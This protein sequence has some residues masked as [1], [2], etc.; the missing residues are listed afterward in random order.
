MGHVLQATNSAWLLRAVGFK[1]DEAGCEEAL[2][3][4]ATIDGVMARMASI[5]NGIVVGVYACGS[6]FR[7]EQFR[8][9]LAFPMLEEL[10]L[11]Y[12]GISE[13]AASQLAAFG[14]LQAL[15]LYDRKLGGVV[16][17]TLSKLPQ[18]KTLGLR[19]HA[20]IEETDLLR[21]ASLH[22]L[23]QLVIELPALSRRS[24]EVLRERLPQCRL[25]FKIDN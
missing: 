1:M 10:Q 12:T 9:L 5:R 2:R 14:E 6:E 4:L 23:E 25:S 18:L 16:F 13:N 17:Y 20:E 8:Q 24:Q 3:Q 15:W 11:D 7:D 22:Q 19:L 21:L